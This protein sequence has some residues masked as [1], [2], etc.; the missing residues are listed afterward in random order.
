MPGNPRNLYGIGSENSTIL[1]I[2]NKSNNHN[3]SDTVLAG[4]GDV[5]WG[6]EG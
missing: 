4:T 5:S 6:G 2:D 3:S 1:R